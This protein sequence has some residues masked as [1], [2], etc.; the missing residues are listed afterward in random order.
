[1]Q[2]R[3]AMFAEGTDIEWA[4]PVLFLR[5]DNAHLF[6]VEAV[7]ALPS[8]QAAQ[9]ATGDRDSKTGGPFEAPATP[10]APKPERRRPPR[11]VRM[12]TYEDPVLSVAF[13]PDGSL[14]A[15][16]SGETVRVWSSP[17]DSN[18]SA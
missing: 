7:T 3:K 14:L 11:V 16:G 4:T 1:V 13:S 8:R 17:H 5:S 12:V 18:R 6:D 2:A 9:P 15:A 10:A